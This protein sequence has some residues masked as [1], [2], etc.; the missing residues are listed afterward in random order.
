MRKIELILK[1]EKTEETVFATQLFG[2][3][4]SDKFFF[5][6]LKETFGIE[7]YHHCFPETKVDFQTLFIIIEKT[8]ANMITENKTI[9]VN[10]EGC[11]NIYLN[12]VMNL[13]NYVVKPRDKFTMYKKPKENVSVDVGPLHNPSVVAKEIFTNS[14]LFTSLRLKYILSLEGLIENCNRCLFGMS[15]NV[16]MLRNGVVAY[17]VSI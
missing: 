10:R 12:P 3:D 7:S 4:F 8:I 2:I 13:T 17:I 6:E 5:N 15:D 16:P 1:D 9:L 11:S 14:I